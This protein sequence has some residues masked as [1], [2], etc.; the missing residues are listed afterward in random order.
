MKAMQNLFQRNLNRLSYF[1]VLLVTCK[2]RGR[3]A[4]LYCKKTTFSFQVSQ[5]DISLNLRSK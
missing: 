2:S 5:Q 1:N 3:A 4:L